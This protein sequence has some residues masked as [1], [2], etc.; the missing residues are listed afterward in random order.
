MLFRKFT[1]VC[2]FH[3]DCAGIL[4]NTFSPHTVGGMSENSNIKNITLTP[5]VPTK[6]RTRKSS[7]KMELPT[8]G[9]GSTSPGTITQLSASHTPSVKGPEPVGLNSDMTQKGAPIQAAGSKAHVPVK[10]I[11][12]EA[13][14]KG[15][16][17]LAAAKVAP[18]EKTRKNKGARKVRMNMKGLN[19]K[20]RVAKTIRQKATKDTI[21]DIKK[22]LEKATLIKVGSKA[23]ESML[24][25]MYADY[26]M[27][28]K[29]A[30]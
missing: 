5:T 15:K 25:Q 2:I 4:E 24:R 27:L 23:P 20:I 29:R 12:A 8:E 13:K 14:K 21:E 10:V 17:L 22:A 3:S 1:Q 9:G 16:V 6:R 30:L 11:L 18:V 28:K 26:M 19:N 7:K